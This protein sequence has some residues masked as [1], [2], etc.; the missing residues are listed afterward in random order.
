MPRKPTPDD[1]RR[2]EDCRRLFLK[3]GGKQHERIEAEMRELGHHDF[4]RRSLY[5]RRE[6]GRARPGWI[7]RF[8]WDEELRIENGELRINGE[9]DDQFPDPDCPHK[10]QHGNLGAEWDE[11]LR[12]ENGELRING[13]DDDQFPD[14]DC[15][16]KVQ[17]GNLGAEREGNSQFSIL[18]SP[19][20]AWLRR[21]SPNL[22]WDWRY[23]QEIYRA[24][25][26]VTSGE[27]KRLMIFL[28]PRHG[29]SELV[30]VR[31][32]A[33]RLKQDPSLNVILAGHT[34]RLANR[35]SRKIKN[36]LCDDAAL[37]A[38]EN[39]ELRIEDCRTPF[40]DR[41][42]RGAVRLSSSEERDR[43]TSRMRSEDCGAGLRPENSATPNVDGSG[44]IR[45][46]F[47]QSERTDYPQC[48]ARDTEDR[49]TKNSQLSILN[50]PFPFTRQRPKN[51]EA[52]WETTVGGGLRA[53]G[54]GSGV[55]GLGAKLIVIDDPIRG[56][57]DAESAVLR[58]KVWDWFSDD[59]YTRLEPDGAIILIQT[60]WHED[61]LA[62]RLLR[63]SEEEGGEKWDVVSFPAIAEREIENGELRMENAE[64][65]ST[66]RAHQA[67]NEINN[68]ESRRVDKG[69][70]SL[71][72]DLAGGRERRSS[73]H[74]QFSILNSHLS[75]DILGRG[76][77]EALCPER[78][79]EAA[80]ERIRR[81]IGTYSFTSL[82]QQRP[83]PPEGGQF[84]RH[85]FRHI[86][87]SPPANVK[88]KRAYDLGLS[89]NVDSDY[90]A[91]FRVGFDGD[92]LYIDGGYRARIDYPEQRRYILGRIEAETDTEHGIELAANGHAVMQDLN[93]EVK[94][95]GRAFR[96]LKPRG[97]KLARAL[98]WIPVAE[99]GR[100]RLVRG[101]WN[102]EFIDEACSFPLGAHDDQIDAVSLAVMMFEKEKKSRGY[103]F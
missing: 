37:S 42:G 21:V 99:D 24:L 97:G 94:L 80:F 12:I 71:A 63:A 93:K 91:S 38:I 82:Y 72:A 57:A 69:E 29:K 62:G 36:V 33:H 64:G 76:P 101:A 88:W 35:F 58:Q 45:N 10:V 31:Y 15:P 19:F 4:N 96:G 43:A 78:Y 25:E 44:P 46:A 11:E 18:N 61:D 60:R 65:T 59:I 66:A 23:Q 49:N 6:R 52:E 56:R 55:T 77:G 74:S 47:R 9:D 79:D 92:I 13:E 51:T 27:S 83:V 40:D 20:E 87:E 102:E 7:E 86:V 22:R 67:G 85:W 70:S 73:E 30:T 100:L 89:K 48:T 5:A 3:Y 81:Q 14:P 1:A 90:T 75:V 54:V 39:G 17:H 103:S 98:S 26:R 34:Q 8:G 68:R 16:H 2:I 28:P 95:R 50:S 53:V 41:T 84:K 32:V